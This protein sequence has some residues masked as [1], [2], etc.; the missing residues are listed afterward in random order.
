MKLHKGDFHKVDLEEGCPPSTEILAN[1]PRADWTAEACPL[2][3][4]GTPPVK[5]GLRFILSW[6]YKV[7]QRKSG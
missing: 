1:V 7:G 3:I 4:F 2:T 6:L 5:Y